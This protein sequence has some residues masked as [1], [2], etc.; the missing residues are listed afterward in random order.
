MCECFVACMSVHHICAYCLWRSEKD[1][2]SP[3]AG[4][5][6][7]SQCVC[8]GNRCSARTGTLYFW[9]VSLARF[10][11]VKF[12]IKSRGQSSLWELWKKSQWCVALWIF[13][14]CYKIV[15]QMVIFKKFSHFFFIAYFFIYISSVIPFPSFPSRNPLFPFAS[16]RVLPNPVTYRLPPTSRW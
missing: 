16:V 6:G 15:F 13:V 2:R 4:I 7:G 11:V 8:S 5:K 3:R 9:A 10:T 14:S 12:H 1:I